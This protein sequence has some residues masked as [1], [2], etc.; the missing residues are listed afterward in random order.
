MPNWNLKW[1]FKPSACR[2]FKRAERLQDVTDDGPMDTDLVL[3]TV[4]A[5][6]DLGRLAREAAER[7]APPDVGASGD[8]GRKDFDIAICDIKR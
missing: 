2:P 7:A 3:E 4:D 5:M 1:D 6:A 8:T